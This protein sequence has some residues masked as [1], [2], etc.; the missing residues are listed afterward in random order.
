[1]KKDSTQT[2][3]PLQ[4]GL[5]IWLTGLSGAGKSTI[6]F[7]LRR[8]LAKAGRQV[9]LLDGDVV[10]RH[11]CSDLGFTEAD[12]KENIRR[13]AEVAH[14]MAETGVICIVA[15]ISPYEADRQQ[16]R[17]LIKRGKFMEVF[18]NAPLAICEKRDPKGH[19]LRARAGQ[20]KQFTGISSPYEAPKKPEIELR[21]DQMT[22]RESMA[23]LLQ[24]LKN[25]HGLIT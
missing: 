2:V 11:L 16:A 15:L 25:Q 10:R 12:R 4:T 9:C 13:V 20:I 22:I 18:I 6:A 14:L 5:V 21:T 24:Y 23:E 8:T 19:Y 1:M 3:R 17:R 7:R